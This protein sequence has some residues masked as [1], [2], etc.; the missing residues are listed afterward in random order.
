M[1]KE[2]IC[3]FKPL[4]FGEFWYGAID[5]QDKYKEYVTASHWHQK[6]KAKT[7]LA[8]IMQLILSIFSINQFI[9]ISGAIVGNK[10]T[11]RNKIETFH[12]WNLKMNS[13]VWTRFYHRDIHS[14]LYGDLRES[15]TDI[16][17]DGSGWVSKRN[18]GGYTREARL[19]S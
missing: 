17:W 9:T 19:K 15:T 12:S 14:V 3:F 10:D 5:T 11:K 8:T 13:I 6:Q 7:L 18:Q 1:N 2:N 16:I 4:N